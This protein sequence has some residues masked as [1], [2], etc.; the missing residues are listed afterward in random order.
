MKNETR[1]SA[2]NQLWAHVRGLVP[3][4]SRGRGAEAVHEVDG[5][6]V[7]V[8]GLHERVLLPHAQPVPPD[9]RHGSLLPA[10]SAQR[11]IERG[12]YQVS[13][14]GTSRVGIYASVL[15]R[16]LFTSRTRLTAHVERRSCWTDIQYHQLSD[17]LQT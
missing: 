8:E 2:L 9:V 3:I 11:R 7:G 12:L 10:D 16:T 6:S 13:E 15:E 1:P 5:V 17:G 4:D 14:G